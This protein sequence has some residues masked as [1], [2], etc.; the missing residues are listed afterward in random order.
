[1]F[2]ADKLKEEAINHFQQG[3]RREALAA[4]EAAA[5]AYGAANQP[6][7][8]AEM[9]NNIG[10]LQRLF[11]QYEAALMTFETAATAFATAG[12]K[13]RQA[14][15]FGNM[16]DLYAARKKRVEAARHYSNAAQLFAEAGDYQRQSE[17]LRA[18]SLLSVRY[19]R[20]LEALAYMEQSLDARPRLGLGQRI[21]RGLIR[22]M[23][24]L[25]GRG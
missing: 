3:H 7:D 22:F 25:M 8:Q 4:F 5:Q 14:M 1:M 2:P 12:D 23:M 20:W 17:V 15:V 18:L 19:M 21:F 10:V 16:G 9:L 6:A 13:N 24:A 11:G